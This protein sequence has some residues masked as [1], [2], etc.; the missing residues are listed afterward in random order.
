MK[1]LFKKKNL[2]NNEIESKGIVTKKFFNKKIIS[3]I[4]AVLVIAGGFGIYKFKFAKSKT[5]QNNVRYT[6]LKK[7][8]VES[9]I[10]SSGTI[11]SGTSTN[12]YSNL[13]YNVQNIN[14]AVGDVVKKGDVLATIDTTTLQQD[15][16]QN[17][18][19]VTSTEQ[20]NQLALANAKQKYDNLQYLHDNNLE[21][22]AI[23]A[24]KALDTDKLDLEEKSKV[25]DYDKAMLQKG[26]V[27][28]D[29]VNKAQTD[30][31]NAQ[32]AVDKD[33]VA[34]EAAKVTDDQNLAQAKSD[35]NTA[36]ATANDQSSELQLQA[37]KD[38]LKN[39]QVVAPVDGTI[40]N[41]NAVVGQ[42]STGALFVIQDLSNLQIT[43]TVDETDI[44]KIKVGQRVEVTTQASGSDIIEGK[45]IS[46]EPVSSATSVSSTNTTSTSSG[47]KTSTSSSSS[48][49]TSTDVTFNVVIQITGQN[50]KIKVGMDS[51]VNIVTDEQDNVYAAP[52]DAVIRKNGKDEVYAA[53]N[54]GGKYVVK[55]VPVTEGL[56]ASADVEIQ[57]D[58]TDGMIILDNPSNYTVGSTVDIKKR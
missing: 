54:E 24:Q 40:T 8:N 30:Y 46:F 19:T 12:V 1:L 52:Y 57:G 6:T 11:K 44:N 45:V 43:A 58:L 56:Q 28:Q 22:D 23:N 51:V 39:G 47:G 15:I 31:Q 49:S 17:Q 3:V 29:T 37:K 9:T 7:T 55:E 32:G 53:V 21:T 41:V 18:Q 33:S 48:S 4:A 26:Q 50:D 10:S 34:L 20:K 5:T 25:L 14:V 13:D 38:Q 16:D 27:S 36:A 35:Y 42:E 2:V